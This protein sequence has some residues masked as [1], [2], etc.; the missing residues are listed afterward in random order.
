VSTRYGNKQKHESKNPVQ[1]ALIKRF[2]REAVRLARQ[3]D[4]SSMLD[5]GCGEGYMLETLAEGGVTASLRG[6]DLSAPAIEDA[7]ARLGARATV[8]V[9][10]ARELI[11][12]GEQFDLVMMLEVLEH[13]PEPAQMLPI[14]EQLT[15]RYLLLSVPWEPFFCGL[16]LCRGKHLRAFG[17]DPEHINHW[18]RKS[19]VRFVSQRFR[20]L[21]TPMVFPWVMALCERV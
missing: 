20:V 10:D 1:R 16:N 4:A 6:V 11:D 9:R 17:N 8:E 13:I 14:L 12:M 2:K 7:S 21:E 15:R 18:G 5:V 19:F 3:I